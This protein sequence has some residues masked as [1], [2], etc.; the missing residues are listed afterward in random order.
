MITTVWLMSVYLI[1]STPQ[2]SR[3]QRFDTMQHC[4]NFLDLAN[5]AGAKNQTAHFYCAE[6]LMD[7]AGPATSPDKQ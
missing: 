7:T 6:G 1:G 4:K 2:V 5:A 3:S